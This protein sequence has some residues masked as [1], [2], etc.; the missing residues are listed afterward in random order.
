M[1]ILTR[2]ETA[3][4]LL[5]HDNY[6]ILSHRRPD[7]DTIGSSAALCLGLRQLGKTA[8]VLYNAEVSP[9]FQW[10]HAGLTK[11]A[12]EE[13]DVIVSVDV[14][15]PGMLSK[16][17][18]KLLGKIR[19]RIDHHGAATS[20]TDAELVDAASA[21]CAEVVWDVLE[22]MGVMADRAIAEAVYVGV[23]TD[24]GCFRYANTSAHTFAVAAE[25]A[26]AQAR[27]YELNQELFETNT[28]GRLRM[29]AWIVD[30]MRLI[31]DGE[32]A[33]CAIPKAVEEEIGVTEDD[34]DNISSFPRTVAGVC[35]AATLRETSDGDTKMSVRAVP[36]YDATL[37]TVPFGGGGHKGAAGASM[38]KPLAEAAKKVEEVMLA[39]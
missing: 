15:S 34:M 33:I 38:K 37:V 17:F 4:F 39:L 16:D 2:N 12:V 6:T 23:S 36:G 13:N 10:L 9:R 5:T 27:I 18:Q 31:R 35:M 28:L 11:E 19:L 32:M 21:S 8:H 14:A 29:Q 26:K 30:H 1:K 25:C 24:T 7:G 22:L 20:F 3:E